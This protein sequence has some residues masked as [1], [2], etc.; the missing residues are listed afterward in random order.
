MRY[1]WKR[2]WYPRG[3]KYRLSEH[4]YLV[5][6]LSQQGMYVNASLKQL[7]EYDE[8]NCLV[9][10]GEPGIGKS[11][12]FEAELNRVKEKLSETGDE[13]VFINLN[14]YQTDSRLIVDAFENESVK[15]WLDGENQLVLFF[16]SLDEGRLS[17]K[18]ISTILSTEL[19]KLKPYA[20][21]L[22]I[23]VAC[24]TAEWS[25]ILE[26]ALS[27]MWSK[28]S[29][30]VHILELAPLSQ[31][32]VEIAVEAN[33]MDSTDFLKQ[34]EKVA[35]EP[36]AFNP[37]S[38]DLLLQIYHQNKSLPSTSRE[39]Y[40]KGCLLLCEEVSET[41]MEAKFTGNLTAEQRLRIASRIAACQIFSGQTIIG[42]SR[43]T[44]VAAG[45]I[46]V[47]ELS[48]DFETVK[49]DKFDVTENGVE[50]TLRTPLFVGRGP[51]QLSFAHKTYAEFL[52]AQYLTSKNLDQEQLSSLLFHPESPEKVIPQL[53]ETAAWLAIQNQ[54]IME[55]IIKGDP[56]VLVR[57]DVATA[58]DVTKE[59]LVK[60]LLDGLQNGVLDDSDWGLKKHYWKLAHPQL[61]KQVRDTLM[62]R[63][64]HYLARRFTTDLAEECC[65]TE[66]LEDLIVIALDPADSTHIR[67]NAVQAAAA[68]GNTE[69][70]NQLLPIIFQPDVDQEL[71]GIVLR[72]L[73]PFRIVK[74]SNVL[75]LLKPPLLKSYF[76]P[77]LH[78]AHC[79]FSEAM[80]AEECVESLKWITKQRVGDEY[81]EKSFYQELHSQILKR[82]FTHIE[83]SYIQDALAGYIVSRITD[84][85]DLCINQEVFDRSPV[86]SRQSLLEKIISSIESVDQYRYELFFLTPR[87]VRSSDFDWLCDQVVNSSDE[88]NTQKWARLI[89]FCWDWSNRYQFERVIKL[90]SDCNVVDQIFSE[91]LHP[92]E[93][94]SEKAGLLKERYEKDQDLELRYQQETERPVIDPSPAERVL[95]CLERFENND[96]DAWWHLNEEMMREPETG[97]IQIHQSLNDD[98]TQFPG[99]PEDDH[100]LQN[101]IVEAAYAFL[102]KWHSDAE[103]WIGSESLD[104]KDAAGYRSFSSNFD[105]QTRANSSTEG[106]DMGDTLSGHCWISSR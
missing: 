100:S 8:T 101:R 69:Y 16:D 78:F 11:T 58:D 41:R 72:R 15:N 73:W 43:T 104:D 82:S 64:A 67:K 57:S 38:L 106:R 88:I 76:G 74:L 54:L 89:E 63:N 66:L 39:I 3:E 60:S 99:W 86:G 30:H 5:D 35:A 27:E 24:R 45:C 102:K 79:D 50:E 68:F 7:S 59:N 25:S 48:G 21:R 4:G 10:L 91:S 95:S 53:A 23:R 77:Y 29:G 61:A 12:E 32:D 97:E 80:T 46:S 52:A 47:S 96:T 92:I 94:G 71:L 42:T 26:K 62:D 18:Q 19:K 28:D 65:L 87:L 34:V 37:V 31:Q 56:Q 17:I 20:N 93:L 6:P 70:Y 22:K 84:Q 81:S 14:V 103:D 105:L 51:N 33:G 85:V 2:Y 9:L 49:N 36:F 75:E 44:E 1:P 98:L 40:S 13:C 90:C 83:D 55:R